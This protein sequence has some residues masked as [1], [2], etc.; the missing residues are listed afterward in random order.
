MFQVCLIDPGCFREI[1]ELIKKETKGKGS[2]EVLNLKD[3]E[4]GDEKFEWHSSISSALKHL[5]IFVSHSPVFFLWS[6]KY[7]L[8]LFDV[9]LLCVKHVHTKKI[10]PK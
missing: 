2:L 8:K 7:L 3:V 4:E 6:A 10:F 9:F 1:D 5:N